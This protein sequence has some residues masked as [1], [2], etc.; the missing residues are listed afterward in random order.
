MGGLGAPVVGSWGALNV[1]GAPFSRWCFG[2]IALAMRPP[3]LVRRSSRSELR[4]VVVFSTN[5]A[6]V[7]VGA[8]VGSLGA[9]AAVAAEPAGDDVVETA[10]VGLGEA[11]TFA[12]GTPGCF[13][14]YTCHPINPRIQRVMAIQ[15]CLSIN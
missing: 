9:I 8:G 2:G 11:S 7:G 15:A 3:R 4:R 13:T 6:G 5:G 12:D 14:M 10:A 1:P